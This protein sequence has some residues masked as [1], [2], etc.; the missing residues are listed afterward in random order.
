MIE[1]VHR[2]FQQMKL[3]SRPLLLGLSGGPDSTA[4]LEITLECIKLPIHVAHVDHGWRSESRDEAAA[5]EAACERRGI[6][7]HLTHLDL[8]P[9]GSNLEERSREARLAFFKTIYED[10]DGQALLLG[11]H[12]DDQAETVLKRLLEGANMAALGGIRKDSQIHGMRLL[13]PLLGLHKAQV[14]SWLDDRKISYFQDRSNRDTRYLRARMRE[15]I[16]P[17]LEGSFGKKVSKNLCQIG[18]RLEE[19]SSYLDRRTESYIAAREGHSLNLEGAT[20][21][22]IELE[23][24]IRRFAKVCDM[25]LSKAQVETM[26]QLVSDNKGE[27]GVENG[28]MRMVY[29]QKRIEIGHK[30]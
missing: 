15:E 3:D 10:I 24:L 7:C 11:H 17:T 30:K 21:D 2:F 5:V 9:A 18:E 16:I 6:P 26:A 23:H 27:R 8:D 12:A 4:L 28:K 1:H 13:R 29:R 14:I 20:L 25:E 19:L 22:P